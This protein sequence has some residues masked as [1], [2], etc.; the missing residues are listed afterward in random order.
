MVG[1]PS[2]GV[3]PRPSPRAGRGSRR[4]APGGSRGCRGALR[5]G[6]LGLVTTA[7]RIV[8]GPVSARATLDDS[9]TGRAIAEALPIEA[10]AQTWGDEIYFAIPVS[11]PEDDAQEVVERGD[12][13]YWPPGRAFCIFFG[14]TPASRGEECRPA[15]P[16]NVFGRVE[17]D[18]TVFRGV[19]AG[20]R[21][22]LERVEAAEPRPS[23]MPETRSARQASR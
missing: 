19:R 11:L 1:K 12:L 5:G 15:S 4:R 14:P 20:T 23:G 21:V 10:A 6:R 2:S 13:G 8:A 17:G 22:R 7:L 18:S 16:V 3:N 9:R